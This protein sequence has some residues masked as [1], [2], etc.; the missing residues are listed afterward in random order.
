MPFSGMSSFPVLPWVADWP[1]PGVL[2]L[3]H[4]SYVPAGLA[5]PFI[6]Q[7]SRHPRLERLHELEAS[8]K[9]GPKARWVLALLKWETEAQ[10]AAILPAPAQCQM[11]A[12]LRGW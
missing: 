12:E 9:G 3:R 10:Q 5:C 2:S 7:R 8:G 11:G 4:P 6:T 1:H